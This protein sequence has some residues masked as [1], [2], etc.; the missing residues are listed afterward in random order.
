MWAEEGISTMFLIAGLVFAAM[1]VA[2]GFDHAMVEYSKTHAGPESRRLSRRASSLA[3]DG[4]R[5]WSR[6]DCWWWELAVAV[7]KVSFQF[8]RWNL[9]FGLRSTVNRMEFPWFYIEWHEV[10]VSKMYC[11]SICTKCLNLSLLNQ[12]L[13]SLAYCLV[14]DFCRKAAIQAFLN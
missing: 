4:K 8:G 3:R 5:Q 14:W 13:G 9:G 10:K 1:L 12:L 7:D 6:S 11:M 2:M